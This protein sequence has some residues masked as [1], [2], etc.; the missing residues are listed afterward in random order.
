MKHLAAQDF[1]RQTK[2][3]GTLGSNA[4]KHNESREACCVEQFLVLG[5]SLENATY[6]GGGSV[7]SSA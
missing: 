1:R 6:Q 2:L 7:R 5:E 4:V 3:A